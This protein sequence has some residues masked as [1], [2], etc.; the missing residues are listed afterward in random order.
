[1]KAKDTL[2][3]NLNL[4]WRMLAT[5]LAAAAL[6]ISAFSGVSVR[7]DT[8]PNTNG[9]E[10][11]A[12]GAQ[13]Q[14]PAAPAPAPAPLDCG[15][16][17]PTTNGDCVSPD[18]VGALTGSPE[19]AAAA[20]TGGSGRHF[21]LTQTNYACN[22]VLTACGSGYHMASLWEILDVSNMIYDYDHPAAH[23]KDDSGQG[24]PSYWHG[25]VRTGWASDGTA[26]VGTGNCRNWTS[27]S[28]NDHGVSVRLSKTWVT[29]P[30][31]IFTWHA[32]DFTCNY[33]GPV[34]CV[35]N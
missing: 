16:R 8:P 31:E 17:L 29:A 6:L 27:V 14:A 32:N 23:R 30:G 4:D 34:W 5:A 10:A 18:A 21:Y 11:Q 7:G 20:V 2:V 19:A 3:I 9:P 28:P 15:D 26:T 12:A 22:Q 1:M 33:T 13:R 25:W 35:R 24:P